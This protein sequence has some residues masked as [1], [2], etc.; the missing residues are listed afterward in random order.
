MTAKKDVTANTNYYG[1]GGVYRPYSWGSGSTSA[2]T[3]Y[4]VNDYIDGSLIIDVVDERTN[5]LVWEGVGNK[6]IDSPKSK[7]PDE[8][9]PAVV[10]KILANFPPGAAKKK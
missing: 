8:V 1:Y 10:G 5:K 7:D 6:E 3:T 2:Y 9:I 4:N